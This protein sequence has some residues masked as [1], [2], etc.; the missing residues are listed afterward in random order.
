MSSE[1]M[2]N[3]PENMGANS[4]DK[5]GTMP[6][7]T[8]ES[9]LENDPEHATVSDSGSSPE[10][11]SADTAE[12]I[13]ASIQENNQAS[14]PGS[15]SEDNRA[16]NPGGHAG[17]ADFR[18]KGPTQE[19]GRFL[20]IVAVGLVS[21]LLGGVLALGL[22]PSVYGWK[23]STASVV[24]SQVSAP[25][26]TTVSTSSTAE[27]FPV[28]AIAKSV[29]PAVVG[30]ANFQSGN[31]LFGNGG[32]TEVGSGSGFII[33][34]QNGYIVT[35]NHVVDGAQKVMVSLADGR[36]L[37]GK[38]V[39][40]DPSRD[41]AVVQIKDA[42]NL[43][44][45]QLGDSNTLQVG[46]PVVAIGNPG[47]QEFARSVTTGVISATNRH[48]D[49][50]G[51]SNFNLIQTDAAINPGNS[52]GPLVNYQGQVIGINS[53]KNQEQGFEGMGFAIPIS[54][55]LPTIKQI[56]EK[57]YASHPALLIEV[58]NRYSP[59]YAKQMGLPAGVYI[60]KAVANGPADQAGLRQGDI[61]TKINGV[62]ISSPDELTYELFKH[63]PGDK[64]TVTYYRNGSA[65]DVQVTLAEVDSNG[66]V[67]KS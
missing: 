58:S 46:Q 42:K 56:I 37:E 13:L 65:Q 53:A 63:K 47:G 61:I 11:I 62:A 41:L 1:Y 20:P 60:S 6:E 3:Y 5:P 12:D 66:K 55:A 50:E 28:V 57:G 27:Q 51:E 43:T 54:D 30:I 38:I 31:S 39:G 16:T 36:D 67:I 8:P 52:G 24:L 64:I 18:V 44:A 40:A 17:T 19:R 21:A 32:L 59:E 48:L 34:A 33:D 14:T 26:A 9:N 45:V 15:H 22:A 35:N 25:A 23:N 4:E 7:N 2:G 29:G 49:L 10:K